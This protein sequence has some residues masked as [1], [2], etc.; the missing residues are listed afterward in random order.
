M[1]ARFSRI[2]KDFALIPPFIPV[3]RRD[4]ETAG[5]F[6]FRF[7]IPSCRLRKVE[8]DG[9][10]IIPKNQRRRD[11]VADAGEQHDRRDRAEWNEQE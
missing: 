3:V 6:G 7:G 8:R 5:R 1:P 10:L 9:A 11:D 2:G 4:S